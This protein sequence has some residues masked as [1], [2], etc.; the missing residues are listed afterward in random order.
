MSASATQSR[1]ERGPSLVIEDVSGRKSCFHPLMSAAGFALFKTGPRRSGVFGFDDSLGSPPIREDFPGSRRLREFPGPCSISTPS[2]DGVSEKRGECG[3]EKLEPAKRVLLDMETWHDWL[4]RG[5][6][7]SMEKDIA[8]KKVF[9]NSNLIYFLAA[10]EDSEDNLGHS[11]FVAGYACLLAKALGIQ[12]ANFQVD[13]ERGAM[14][15]DIG[16]IGIPSGVLKK[17]A[18]LTMMEK[19]I[20]KDHPLLGFCLIKDL[21]FLK[22]AARVVLFHHE[23]FDGRGYP[24][25][26]AGEEIPLEAR[27]FALADTLDAITSDRPYRNGMS[28][29]TARREVEKGSGSQFDPLIVDV[30]LSIPEEKWQQMRMETSQSLRA[31]ITH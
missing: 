16:K 3:L 10:V 22:R 28:F 24:F 19:E 5:N 26:L 17:K 25:G 7:F 9:F 13:L 2:P 4:F 6:P 12:D 18:P 29:R 20:I 1:A 21:D 23:H 27:I 15:H 31:P 8:A 14:L 30:F 11:Q